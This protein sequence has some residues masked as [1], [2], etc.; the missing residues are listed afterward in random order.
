MRLPAHLL[1]FSFPTRLAVPRSPVTPQFKPMLKKETMELC[2][3]VLSG[4]TLKL[5][6]EGALESATRVVG[7]IEDL[8]AG[9]AST[10]TQEV[11]E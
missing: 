1:P 5:G 8:K 11:A 2:L 6:D 4:L 7:A 9:L 10:Q 3:G